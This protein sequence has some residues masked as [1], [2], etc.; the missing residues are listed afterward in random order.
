MEKLP[1]KMLKKFSF[2]FETYKTTK[3]LLFEPL[4]M[5]ITKKTLV[6]LG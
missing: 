5:A 2:N 6:C 4:R 3:I 1:P